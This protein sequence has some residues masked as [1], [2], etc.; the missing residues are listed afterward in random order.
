MTALTKQQQVLNLRREGLTYPELVEKFGA[1][2]NALYQAVWHAR[3]RAIER[4]VLITPDATPIFT[5]LADGWH[6]YFKSLHVGPYAEYGEA[7][8][9]LDRAIHARL[10]PTGRE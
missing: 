6:G 1:N 8:I 5:E 9:E 2:R 7:V 3:Q 10:I 4:G